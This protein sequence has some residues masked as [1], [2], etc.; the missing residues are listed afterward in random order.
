MSKRGLY[1]LSAVGCLAGYGWLFYSW[2]MEGT[3]PSACLFKRIYHIPCPAC[4]STR[5]VMEVFQGHLKEAFMLNPNGLLLT[6]ILIALPLW[7]LY[8]GV[9]K[10]DSF[11]R[12]YKQTDRLLGKKKV[13]GLFALIVILNWIWTIYKDL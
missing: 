11:F 5:A 8:D 9:L 13:F 3:G 12:F 6:A 1:I 10:K 4:G 7:L 2:A